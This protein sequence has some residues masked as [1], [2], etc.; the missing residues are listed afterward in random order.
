MLDSKL[1]TTRV[2]LNVP[3]RANDFANY[4][5]SYLQ[6]FKGSI[7][8]HAPTG[9]RKVVS[10]MQASAL[11]TATYFSLALIFL[12]PGIFARLWTL[13]SEEIY[14]AIFLQKKITPPPPLEKQVHLDIRKEVDQSIDFFEQLILQGSEEKL[15]DHCMFLSTFELFLREQSDVL[16]QIVPAETV[17]RWQRLRSACVQKSD[18]DEP[19]SDFINE[20]APEII[21]FLR[22]LLKTDKDGCSAL[23]NEK[24]SFLYHALYLLALKGNG[25][26]LNEENK[27][28]LSYFYERCVTKL[29]EVGLQSQLYSI[30]A[31]QPRGVGLLLH[32]F[33][34]D[35][36]YCAR[37]SCV[38]LDSARQSQIEA[39]GPNDEDHSRVV[40]AEEEDRFGK[41][42]ASPN[43][44]NLSGRSII[45][46]TLPAVE[47]QA[48]LTSEVEFLIHV[49][50]EFDKTLEFLQELDENTTKEKMQAC[51]DRKKFGPTE[52][53]KLF[54]FCSNLN[55]YL[56]EFR[57]SLVL[58][59]TDSSLKKWAVVYESCAQK[60]N[61]FEMTEYLDLVHQKEEAPLA[62]SIEFI[63]TRI[64][65][66]IQ[67]LTR[68][69]LRQTKEASLDYLRQNRGILFQAVHQLTLE[70]HRKNL[71]PENLRLLQAF[72]QKVVDHLHTFQLE[73]HLRELPPSQHHATSLLVYCFAQSWMV[74]P[75]D[76]SRD[77]SLD[78]QTLSYK[79][80]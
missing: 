10:P 79:T 5:F 48:V 24:P 57:E 19:R 13:R 14:A 72:Y 7:V 22:S 1:Y 4:C 25:Q 2:I 29:H 58:F 35:L 27:R 74:S 17:Q 18:K 30:P 69:L 20:K 26:I 78:F 15:R 80:F 44:H 75:P 59:L 71:T 65:E 61:R 76:R 36:L 12:I 50:S 68:L 16:T 47:R 11:K 41:V 46:K 49:R 40:K 62:E 53:R 52:C 33:G 67:K 37:S 6:H 21:E 56:L 28:S 77:R 23:I 34:E 55:L 38:N 60:L 51:L 54:A 8:V 66:L 70:G 73:K 3:N 64:R 39:C 31:G 42:A 63:N 43:S 9:A 45:P 32:C